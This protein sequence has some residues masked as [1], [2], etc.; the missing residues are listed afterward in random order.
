MHA[1]ISCI[2]KACNKSTFYTACTRH[3]HIML[4]NFTYCIYQATGAY[5]NTK[6]PLPTL[7]PNFIITLRP[8]MFAGA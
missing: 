2:T 3:H 7:S 4:C 1:S 6:V 8:K 5:L